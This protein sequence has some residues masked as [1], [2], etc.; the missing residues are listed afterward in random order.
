MEL[1][2]TLGFNEDLHAEIISAATATFKKKRNALLAQKNIKEPVDTNTDEQFLIDLFRNQI[3]GAWKQTASD[4]AR[5][6]IDKRL[7]S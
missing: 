7:N 2:K 4:D 6:A 3:I 5:N 1:L